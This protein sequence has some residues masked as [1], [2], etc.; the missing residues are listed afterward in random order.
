MQLIID[1]QDN[2]IAEKIIWFLNSL[3]DKGVKIITPVQEVKNSKQKP[4]FT[5]EFI[6]QHWK[7]LGMN[8]HS[9]NL[10]DDERSYESAWEFYSEKHSH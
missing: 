6:L 2:S 3:K 1:V 4:I 10:D 5:D 8:T 7:E 9:A